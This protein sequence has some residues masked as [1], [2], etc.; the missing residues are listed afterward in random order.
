MKLRNVPKRLS[1]LP[2]RYSLDVGDLQDI[3]KYRE[4][5]KSKLRIACKQVK[6]LNKI[7]NVISNK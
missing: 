2:L 3:N 5:K 4:E 7:Y 6:T 1:N